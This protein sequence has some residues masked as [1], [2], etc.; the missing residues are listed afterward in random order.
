[1]SQEFTHRFTAISAVLPQSMRRLRTVVTLLA[2]VALF[3]ILYPASAQAGILDEVR[4]LWQGKAEALSGQNTKSVQTMPL[5]KPAMNIDPNPAKG[6]GD[7]TIVDDDALLPEE[8]PSGTIA[9]IEKTKNQSISI[10]VV[11][12]GD[13]LSGIAEMF[14]VSV[15]TIR[16]ANDIAPGGKIRVGQQLTILPITSVKHTVQKGD[17]LASI[18]K[19][20]GAD[21]DE[22]TNY[23][24][25]E[26]ALVVGTDIIIP[27]G[28]IA[29]PTPK[30]TVKTASSGGASVSS[31]GAYSNPLPGGR[32]T[33][34]IHGYNGVDLAAPV[35]TPIL[36][37]A[38]GDVIIARAGGYNGGYGSY[39]VVK[40]ANGTQTLYAHMSAVTVGIGESVGAGQ[41][42]GAVGSSGRSTGAHLHFEIRGGPRN[43]F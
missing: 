38:A 40:H 8:G 20:Y 19:K 12:E 32:R 14:D 25:I 42:I 37:A 28:E 23:N 26:G 27:D 2:L 17:T 5:P 24:R 9:D 22:I 11:R 34:G 18:A 35:G 13:T 36:A 1:M 3:G 41:V 33:Q 10:Y 21:A 43:P 39:V 30:A 6:G 7:V 16:W 31:S 29:V 4:S 15:N